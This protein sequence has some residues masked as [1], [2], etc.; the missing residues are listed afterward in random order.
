MFRKSLEKYDF[1]TIL[2]TSKIQLKIM[3]NGENLGVFGGGK[4]LKN[5]KKN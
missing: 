5:L 1:G 3:K 4:I 2:K